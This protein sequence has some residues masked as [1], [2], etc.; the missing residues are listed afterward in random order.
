M[1]DL[2]GRVWGNSQVLPS[3]YEE[4]KKIRNPESPEAVRRRAMEW[5]NATIV[6]TSSKHILIVSHG[7]WIR[8]S[9]QGLLERKVVRAE[10]GVTVGRCLNT[11]VTVIEIPRER[12]MGKL[13]Q[14]GNVMHLRG[15]DVVQDNA[16]EL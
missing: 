1:G 14:Y 10:R 12:G 15:G 8:L 2:E 4:G 6:G 7:A 5:W 16:D 3:G 13:L 11:G 9:V